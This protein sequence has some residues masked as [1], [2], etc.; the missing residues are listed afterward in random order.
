MDLHNDGL[1]EDED[2]IAIAVVSATIAFIAN[3]VLLA[4]LIRDCCCPPA[5]Y[6]REF[7]RDNS[8]LSDQSDGDEIPLIRV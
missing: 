6:L 5:I 2:L 7:P 4:C 8:E 3:L 1:P